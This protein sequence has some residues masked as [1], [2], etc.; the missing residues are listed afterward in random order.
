MSSYA[1]AGVDV[2]VELLLDCGR[3]L[4]AADAE[5]GVTDVVARDQR[6]EVVLRGVDRDREAEADVPLPVR[7]LELCVDADNLACAVEQRAARV[8][9][10]DRRVGLDGV[11]DRPPRDRLD[12]AV[13]A[14]DDADRQGAVAVERVPDSERRFADADRVGVAQFERFDVARQVD[15][16][17]RQVA[18]RVGA[19][20]LAVDGVVAGEGHLDGGRPGHDMVVREDVALVVD[21]EAGAAAAV[22]IDADD[23]GAR[24][25]VDVRDARI[26]GRRGHCSRGR[27]RRGG[28]RGGCAIRGGSCR[29]GAVAR[30]RVG[31][32]EGAGERCRQDGPEQEHARSE[33]DQA[34][35]VEHWFSPCAMQRRVRLARRGHGDVRRVPLASHSSIRESVT[36][37]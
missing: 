36:V 18:P 33:P 29:P 4:G 26:A 30:W 6:V 1:D 17:Q 2:E 31:A 5:V 3:H 32:A 37:L 10:V 9:R 19:A 22:G 28:R 27:R 21:E 23:R 34:H 15:R 25:V 13:H 7:V 8:P 11:A 14:T 20:D 12:R 24:R 16:H 35:P